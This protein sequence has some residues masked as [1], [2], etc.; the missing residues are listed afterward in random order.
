MAPVDKKEMNEKIAK[1]KEVVRGIGQNE[2]VMA[3]HS[4]DLDVEKTIQALCENRTAVLDEW[5]SSAATKKQ[6]NRAQKKKV[7]ADT[8]STTTET[9]SVSSKT[10]TVL[11]SVAMKSQPK[12]QPAQSNGYHAP[13]AANK[14]NG[15]DAEWLKTHDKESSQILA[16]FTQECKRGNKEI[17]STFDAIRQA[18]ANREKIL[19]DALQRSQQDAE[20]LI[21]DNKSTSK[22][23]LSRV[24]AVRGDAGVAG[25][26]KAFA[27]ARRAEQQL[28]SA[29]AF[30][31]DMSQ[32]FDALNKFG[33]VPEVTRT[34]TQFSS[35]AAASPSPIRHA[36]SHSSIISS[37]H[38]SGVGG[39]IS[40]VSIDEKK[41]AVVAKP[42]SQINAGGL[43][44]SSD[45]LTPEQLE[46]L[47]KIMQAQLAASGIDASVVA[48]GASNGLIAARPRNKNNN[49]NKDKRQGPG[50]N[51]KP[52]N[53]MKKNEKAPQISILG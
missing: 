14:E 7:A 32:L 3:L 19:L 45:G 31:Y 2:I 24:G 27:N 47:Q 42:L 4:F 34:G 5:E 50:Q 15:G 8:A 22:S 48:G 36:A 38:D 28:A 35:F 44:V 16:A 10:E 1:V 30:T 21:Q 25:D 18:L 49:N 46:N 6:K 29:S 17:R 43:Q 39:H 51:G 20:K 52:A 41:Q 53:G 33:S 12:K 13:P 23:L 11:P 37:D 40:P 9:P 26:L